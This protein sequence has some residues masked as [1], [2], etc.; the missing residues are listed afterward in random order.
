MSETDKAASDQ[1]YAA[2]KAHA[3]G[4]QVDAYHDG[5][6]AGVEH[7]R[8]TPGPATVKMVD[9]AYEMIAANEWS[10]EAQATCHAFIAEHK[11]H[12]S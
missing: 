1:A 6:A 12:P 5:F 3:Y 4:G 8:R 7:A 10:A 9:I 2:W 11:P